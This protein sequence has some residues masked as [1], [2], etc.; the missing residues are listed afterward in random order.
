MDQE[1]EGLSNAMQMK[2]KEAEDILVNLFSSVPYKVDVDSLRREVHAALER[3]FE[4]CQ[5]GDGLVLKL[6]PVEIPILKA[7]LESHRDQ[8]GIMQ[9]SAFPLQQGKIMDQLLLKVNSL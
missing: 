3:I 9:S 2:L 6:N 1:R 8:I 4:A 7:A 5:N